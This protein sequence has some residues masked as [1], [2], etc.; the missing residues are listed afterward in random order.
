MNI[1]L[2]KY[3]LE[4]I[5]AEDS[6]LHELD[7]YTHI[8]VLRPRML[9]GH[10][11][12]SILKMI[13]RMIQPQLALEIGSFTGYS[14]ISMIKGM[15]TTAHL[16]TI[17]VN[18]ELESTLKSFFAK[19]EVENQLTLHIGKALE[20]IPTLP[21]NFDLIFIDGDKRE[22]PQYYE[23]VFNKL[24]P[25]GFIVADNVLWGGKVTEPNMPDDAYT[26]GIMDFNQLVAQDK[27]VEKIILPLRD[28][29][30]LIRKK[31]NILNP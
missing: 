10:L 22:Y 21:N 16:H 7:R 27:R 14:A 11:Q 9:S 24:N 6:V 5:D 31:Q 23:A 20:V 25:G 26:K 18:D 19:A 13:C 2:E 1:D 17:E 3:I 15:P 28:G 8:N 4:H 29:L 30:T 12:G